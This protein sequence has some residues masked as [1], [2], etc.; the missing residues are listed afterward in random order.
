MA[1]NEPSGFCIAGGHIY[2]AKSEDH[3]HEGGVLQQ[4]GDINLMLWHFL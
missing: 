2:Y 1:V 3:E 4:R